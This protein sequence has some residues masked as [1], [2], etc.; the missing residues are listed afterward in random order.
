VIRPPLEAAVTAAAGGALA[1]VVGMPFDA[2]VLLGAVGA[3]NGA[4]SGW[5]G[6]YGWSRPQG[7]VAFVLDSTWALVTTAGGLVS[8]AIGVVRGRPG[9]LPELSARRDR[10]VYARGF[11]AR[12]GFAI[13][14]GNVV[15][16]IGGA[17][18][19]SRRR[20][21]TDHEDVHVWQARTF[22]PL[23]PVLY[24]AWMIA[25]GVAG[26]VL[27]V[28]K[29]RRHRCS[30]VIETCAYYCNPFE[31]WAYSRD[32]TWR[33]RRMVDGVGWQ[34]PIVRPLRSRRPV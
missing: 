21:V 24:V 30:L 2:A 9:Y 14:I 10:H 12:R 29:H 15:S 6:T 8:H 7:W 25:A 26:T 27:W 20:L 19:P 31:W 16:G 1:A 5:R 17:L 4:V 13:T 3:L 22:G 33:P 23:F 18:T 28:A 32:G 11:Q 34:R